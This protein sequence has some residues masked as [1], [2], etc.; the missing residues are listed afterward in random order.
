VGAGER[1]SSMCKL[2]CSGELGLR[3]SRIRLAGYFP[4]AEADRRR[5]TAHLVN[6]ALTFERH[7]RR[8]SGQ[9]EACRLFG[10]L[11][12]ST[13]TRNICTHS[14]HPVTS[15]SLKSRYSVCLNTY[16]D[17]S[18]WDIIVSE[19]YSLSVNGGSIDCINATRLLILQYR[20]LTC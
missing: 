8:P 16:C 20:P 9:V 14:N 15:D 10:A 6:L 11:S 5:T 3:R 19:D 4:L 1:S 17:T 18:C 2:Q 13:D 12:V 7:V